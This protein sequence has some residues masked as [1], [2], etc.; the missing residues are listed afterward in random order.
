MRLIGA[1]VSHHNTSLTGTASKIFQGQTAF[2]NVH[3]PLLRGA[4]ELKIS[5]IGPNLSPHHF[6]IE[7]AM[8]FA[9]SLFAE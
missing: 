8:R 7:W 1:S 4:A 3:D 9:K 5:A 2:C 6:N